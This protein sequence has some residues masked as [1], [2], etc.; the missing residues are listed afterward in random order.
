LC[1]TSGCQEVRKL[2]DISPEDKKQQALFKAKTDHAE[3]NRAW[4][5]E[6]EVLVQ[7]RVKLT[8]PKSPCTSGKDTLYCSG[9]E[10]TVFGSFSTE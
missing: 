10:W 6:S 9:K 4:Y 3:E 8:V 1:H 2:F 5:D 7:P